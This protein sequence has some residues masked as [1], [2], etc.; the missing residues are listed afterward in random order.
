[1]SL[2]Q[3]EIR[4]KGLIIGFHHPFN[5][6]QI[7]AER[8]S[9]ALSGLGYEVRIAMVGTQGIA[10]QLSFLDKSDLEFFSKKFIRIF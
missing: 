10:N 7:M 8:I 6:I 1:M 9:G 5:A 3:F 4:K 2:I